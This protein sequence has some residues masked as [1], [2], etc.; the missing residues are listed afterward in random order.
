MEVTSAKS[1]SCVL[2]EAGLEVRPAIRAP[3]GLEASETQRPRGNK[4]CSYSFST[5]LLLAHI[6]QIR[7][8]KIKSQVSSQSPGLLTWLVNIGLYKGP[9][10]SFNR[11][12]HD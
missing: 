9:F 7:R 11:D 2:A 3:W 6:F 4:K 5:E 8:P 1:H 10:T 12:E